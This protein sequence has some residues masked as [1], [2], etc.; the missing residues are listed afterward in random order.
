MRRAW[1]RADIRSCR[2]ELLRSSVC[3]TTNPGTPGRE[4]IIAG[5][6]Q[7]PHG[8]VLVL[9]AAQAGLNWLLV[10]RKRDGYRRA[11]AQFESR[12]GSS[13]H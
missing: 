2:D 5:C 12:E 7:V 9:S 6:P 1:P 13:F 8:E 3:A 11:F 10:L 4:I